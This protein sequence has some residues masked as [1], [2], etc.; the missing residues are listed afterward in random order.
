MDH[1]ECEH[2]FEMQD[3]LVSSPCKRCGEVHVEGFE[4]IFARLLEA[5]V[6][7]SQDGI[8]GPPGREAAA[9]LRGYARFLEQSR[10]L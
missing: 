4:T 7:R 1:E 3:A 5:M 2:D 6:R 8:L 9:W 10:R